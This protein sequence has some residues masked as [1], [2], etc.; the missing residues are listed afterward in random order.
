MA[1]YYLVL[2]NPA[3]EKQWGETRAL[4]GGLWLMT[5]CLLLAAYK[6]TFSNAVLGFLLA[7]VFLRDI[8]CWHTAPVHSAAG[9]KDAVNSILGPRLLARQGGSGK[10]KAVLHL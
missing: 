2:F 3:G 1:F 6:E 5:Y 4:R 7:A 10:V 9:M 8:R